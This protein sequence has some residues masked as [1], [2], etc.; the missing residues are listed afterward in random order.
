M[1]QPLTSLVTQV[2]ELLKSTVT[3]V[4]FAESCTAGLVSA[5]L[6]RIPGISEFHCGSA[7]VYRLDTKTQWLGIS[8]A[9]LE[10]PGPVSS[11]VGRAMAIGVLER[12]PEAR[13]SVAITGHLGPNA[14]PH[15]D[16]LV[17]VGVARRQP[18]GIHVDCTRHVLSTQPFDQAGLPGDSV[19]EWRQWK[20][21]EVVL[22]TLRNELINKPLNHSM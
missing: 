13:M 10:D 17:F 4:V 21:V 3:R 22:E 1:P 9:L 2:A 19:R 11:E 6:G 12:T 8:P 20:A 18:D 16:G 7:V 15:Q 14:P 5:S